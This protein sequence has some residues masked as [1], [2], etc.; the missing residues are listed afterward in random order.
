MNRIAIILNSYHNAGPSNVMKR[1]MNY[2]SRFG[3][4]IILI[5]LFKKTVQMK[6][7]CLRKMELE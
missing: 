6:S 3:H 4:Q 1:I 2:L 7:V 5:T